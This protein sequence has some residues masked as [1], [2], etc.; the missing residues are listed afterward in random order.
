MK[1]ENRTSEVVGAILQKAD[2]R[3]KDPLVIAHDKTEAVAHKYQL[4]EATLYLVANG[5]TNDAA[6]LAREALSYD[7]LSPSSND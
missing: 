3:L 6:T 5:H 7:P 4:M 1:T 2:K